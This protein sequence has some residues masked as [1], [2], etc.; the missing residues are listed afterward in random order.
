MTEEKNR[1][2]H[3]SF[4]FVRFVRIE[5]RLDILINNA[6]VMFIPRTESKDGLEM[7]LAV[8]HF[9]PFLLTNLLLD[10]LKASM[11]SRIINV[12]SHA[13]RYGRIN[14]TDL[15]MEKSYNQY[16]SYFQSKLANILFTRALAKRLLATGVTVNSLHP[17]TVRIE[18]GRR[19]RIL[20][21][22]LSPFSLFMKTV[23]SG[24]QTTISLAVD[25][26]WEQV[27]G[28]YFENC[29]IST[30]SECARDDET[31]EWLWQTS[32]FMTGLK[33]TV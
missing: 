21:I 31:A 8:N 1:L 26:E 22:I 10:L 25:P 18:L 2:K 28:R 27:S 30:E 6:G 11:P 24:A 4:L 33:D 3:I 23:K 29:H 7:Q 12:S 14:R 17:G 9:G 32:E 19:S 16:H 15:N 13:H 20:D 5:N